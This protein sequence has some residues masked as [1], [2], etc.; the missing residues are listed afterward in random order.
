MAE[1][2]DIA[3]VITVTTPGLDEAIPK[4]NQLNTVLQSMNYA[5]KETAGKTN[6]LSDS[7]MMM[8]AATE[9]ATGK[10]D[11]MNKMTY[12]S[13]LIVDDN[14]A[15]FQKYRYQ[16]EVYATQ[17]G[18]VGKQIETITQQ[19]YWFGIGLMFVSMSMAR[20]ETRQL[21]T[22]KSTYS[23][24]QSYQA[25]HEAQKSAM[26]I[27]NKYGIASEEYAVAQG[28]VKQAEFQLALQKKST[29]MAIQQENLAQLQFYLG[30]MPLLINSYRMGATAM[31][32]WMGYQKAKLGLQ[33]YEN[34]ANVAN[35]ETGLFRIAVNNMSAEATLANTFIE[36][37]EVGT[38]LSDT[39]AKLLDTVATRELTF[40]SISLQ[41]ILTGGISL[42]ASMGAL[43][44][45]QALSASSAS[46]EMKKL[47]E[48][49][50]SLSKTFEGT[51]VTGNAVNDMLTGHSLDKSAIKVTNEFKKLN[52]EMN[53]TSDLG[54]VGINVKHG[55]VGNIDNIPSSNVSSTPLSFNISFPNLTIREEADMTKFS[56][57][58]FKSIMREL[59]NTGVRP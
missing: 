9:E 48:Q 50:K 38:L 34:A 24:A 4:V 10:V 17:T 41:A 43:F 6:M 19:V 30:A 52:D 20:A 32:M 35:A 1:N 8:S 51:T 47:D 27:M 56:N 7:Y 26:D 14:T 5:S 2:M 58:M 49:A 23:L 25:L 11:K 33:A 54:N 44:A 18:F 16:M 28:K 42:V 45:V 3:I 59:Q 12:S 15:A 57:N 46:E 22:E 55:F 36:E 31:N 53:K 29:Q 40:A 13:Q 39:E 21:T 37:V